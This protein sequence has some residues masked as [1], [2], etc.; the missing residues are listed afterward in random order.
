VFIK[1]ILSH[2]HTYGETTTTTALETSEREEEKSINFA[3]DK[4]SD[5]IFMMKK[6]QANEQQQ[7]EQHSF[8]VA[9]S[10]P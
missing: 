5:N 8:S 3:Q 2:S 6:I 1:S 10:S 9:T 4:R 7:Q